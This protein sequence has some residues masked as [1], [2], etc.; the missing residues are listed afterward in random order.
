MATKPSDTETWGQSAHMGKSRLKGWIIHALCIG[1]PIGLW[2]MDSFHWFAPVF[3]G[4]VL[5][6]FWI[7]TWQNYNGR[8][9]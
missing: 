3:T 6:A 5:V 1:I 9:A 7:A 2:A 8:Q 4:G